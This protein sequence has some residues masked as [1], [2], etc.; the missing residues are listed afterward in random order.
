MTVFG[1]GLVSVPDDVLFRELDGEAII[2][3]LAKGVYFGLDVVGTRI[4]MVLAES[5]SVRRAIDA[6]VAEYDV[7]PAVAAQDV[8]DL[9]SELR[10]RG[11]IQV[12]PPESGA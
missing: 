11:L 7:E 6:V 3:D 10:D 9:V 1:E 4:W 8:L 12:A 5:A 2:L